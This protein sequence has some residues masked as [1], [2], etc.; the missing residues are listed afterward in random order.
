MELIY[1]EGSG[2][3]TATADLDALVQ[4]FVF[5]DESG[6]LKL[7]RMAKDYYEA[8]TVHMAANPQLING[9]G[10]DLDIV[11]AYVEILAQVNSPHLTFFSTS[12][13]VVCLISLD[14]LTLTI[15][16]PSLSPCPVCVYCLL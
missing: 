9:L 10:R 7:F 5:E 4:R 12:H 3:A 8:M 14:S 2:L 11:L 13:P 15:S 6:R 16:S 1:R